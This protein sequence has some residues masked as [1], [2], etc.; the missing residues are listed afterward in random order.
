[1]GEESTNN[2]GT[3]QQGAIASLGGGKGVDLSTS[4]LANFTPQGMAEDPYK[5]LATPSDFTAYNKSFYTPPVYG[6]DTLFPGMNQPIAVGG[7]AN[8]TLGSYQHF[9]PTGQYMPFDILQKREKALQEA[10]ALRQQR[11]SSLKLP[12]SPT[13]KD[14]YYQKKLD[15]QFISTVDRYKNEAQSLYGDNWQAALLDPNAPETDVRRRFQQ[16]LKAY[17]TLKNQTDIITGKAAEVLADDKNIYGPQ[18]KALAKN[19]YSA[20][21]DLAH[22]DPTKINATIDQLKGTTELSEYLHDNV[23]PQ[24]EPAVAEW[25]KVGEEGDY[26]VK[27]SGLKS[28]VE[29][30]AAG[31]AKQLK[32]PGGK[33]EDFDFITED[34]IKKRIIDQFG[35]KV[36]SKTSKKTSDL[37]LRR[38]GGGYGTEDDAS[39]RLN[40]INIATNPLE[41]IQLEGVLIKDGI[42]AGSYKRT[43]QQLTQEA[44]A[45]KAAAALGPLVGADYMG[46]KVSDAKYEIKEDASGTMVP[47]IS[48]TVSKTKQNEDGSEVIIG[49]SEPIL[50]NLNDPKAKSELNTI[51]NGSK[52]EAKITEDQIEKASKKNIQVKRKVLGSEVSKEEKLTLAEYNAKGG[53]KYAESQRAKGVTVKIKPSSKKTYKTKYGDYSEEELINTYGDKWKEALKKI[54]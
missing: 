34:M 22:G 1:M 2:I 7:G 47:Y 31:I 5:G 13:L 28:S 20:L 40:K 11:L 50:I 9:V 38:V 29:A 35:K 52:G 16:E 41:G 17:E 12:S 43:P 45:S 46:G 32:G 23:F 33:Y 14:P 4:D 6:N 48:L 3:S 39:N 37:A 24:L 42:N 53:K 10:A 26:E 49:E 18:E 8:A 25:E 19:I 44:N 30:Q 36:E 15:Q 51:Y 54:Q 21:G 27:R